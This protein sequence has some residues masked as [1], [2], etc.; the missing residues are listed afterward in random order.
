MIGSFS[1]NGIESSEFDLVCR[2]VTRPLL[3]AAKVKRVELP[4]ASGL[5]DWWGSEY[6]TRNITMR[7]A[8]IGK[9]FFELRKRAR[10]I[11]AW[12]GGPQTWTRLILNDEPDKYYLARVTSN[13]D[14]NTFFEIGSAE[15]VF[16]CQPFAYSITEETHTFGPTG[17][18]FV[19]PGTREINFRSPQGSKFSIELTGSWGSLSITLNGIRMTYS[20]Q[21]NGTLLIDSVNMEAML[22]GENVFKNLGGDYAYFFSV[23]PGDN[24]LTVSGLTGTINLSYI[25]MWL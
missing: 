24:T 19:N 14:L 20:V 22:G 18:S 8:Y 3:P 16:D 4:G 1:F 21:G 23:I 12:L 6:A 13:L 11:A 2:S 9:D 15:V 7:I 17:G 25:P 10:D 5:Y